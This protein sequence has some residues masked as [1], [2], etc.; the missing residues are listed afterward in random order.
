MDTKNKDVQMEAYFSS[1]ANE[2]SD[3][4]SISRNIRISL[5][6]TYYYSSSNA[7]IHVN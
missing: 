6:N 2:I 5:L 1:A 7:K 4:P 3:K